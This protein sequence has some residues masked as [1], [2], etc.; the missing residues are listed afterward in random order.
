MTMPPRVLFEHTLSRPAER[1][2]RLGTLS[3]FPIAPSFSL[4]QP[5][6]RSLHC[7]IASMSVHGYSLANLPLRDS[8]LAVVSAALVSRRLPLP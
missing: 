7:S 1:S 2:L 8:F 4:L 5:Q 6:R 3:I